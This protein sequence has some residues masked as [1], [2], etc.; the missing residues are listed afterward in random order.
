MTLKLWYMLCTQL[1]ANPMRRLYGWQCLI[2]R[3]LCQLKYLKNY[4]MDCTEMFWMC[5]RRA[6][7]RVT[8]VIHWL[9]KH[10]DDQIPA[11][12]LAFP[13]SCTLCLMLIGKLSWSLVASMTDIVI[14][15]RI[16]IITCQTAVFASSLWACLKLK[17]LLLGEITASQRR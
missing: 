3:Q 17:T 12:L 4:W 5:G 9:F 8:L 1:L 14:L 16:L 15:L 10:F 13:I 7:S 6:R 11:K 2:F